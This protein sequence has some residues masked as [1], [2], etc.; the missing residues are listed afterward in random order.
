MRGS[1]RIRRRRDFEHLFRS[2]RRGRSGP[3]RVHVGVSAGPPDRMGLAVGRHVGGAVRRNRVKRLLRTAFRQVHDAWP[4]SLD[5]VV[6]V[7]PHDPVSLERYS[8]WL[9]EAV[10]RAAAGSEM[11]T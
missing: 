5:V 8:S 9:D 10:R 3:L 6:V 11:D 2:G 4:G 1:M 7:E